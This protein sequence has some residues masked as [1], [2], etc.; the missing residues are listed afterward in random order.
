MSPDIS[1][2]RRRSSSANSAVAP[3]K[4]GAHNHRLSFCEGRL[5]LRLTDR[6]R[7]MDPGSALALLAW[8]GRRVKFVG[9]LLPVASAAAT[10][11]SS[12]NGARTDAP[13]P[14]E[15]EVLSPTLH[16][17]RPK[18]AFVLAGGGSF[19]AIQ[20]GMMHSLAKHGITPD[21]VVGSSVGALN[22]AYYAGNRLHRDPRRLHAG[23][24][25]GPLSR[26]WRDLVQ[27]AD[28][29]R[30]QAGRNAPDHPAD[31]T[32]LRDR[33]AAGRCGCQRPACADALDRAAA[34]D[35]ARKPRCRDRV[36]CGSTAM[37]AGGLT[38]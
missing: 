26:R 28:Q 3:A 24:L 34:R 23:S 10:A 7:G 15:I 31:W 21:M 11:I 38:L 36:L 19:G 1:S 2:S 30:R 25:P 17:E 8:P 9:P 4:A 27:H 12:R 32:C 16:L 14:G 13:M 33:G 29:D 5:P 6:S 18:T 20:V 22:G 35:R 37:P